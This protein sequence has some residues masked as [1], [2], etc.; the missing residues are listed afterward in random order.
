MVGADVGCALG[1]PVGLLVGSFVFDK[2]IC[3]VQFMRYSNEVHSTLN[4]IQQISP[5][6]LLIL[7]SN[8]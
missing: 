3:T 8:H 1:L 5:V 7:E 6:L 2:R 4:M